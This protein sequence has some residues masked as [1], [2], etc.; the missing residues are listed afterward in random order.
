MATT[1]PSWK[2]KFLTRAKKEGYKKIL[3]KKV[4]VTEETEAIPDSDPD[5]KEK[6]ANREL[7]ENAYADLIL[8]ID[9]T[10]A[11]GRSV[12]NLIKNTK[13]DDY[14]DGN[15][16]NAWTALEKKFEPKTAPSQAKLHRLFY[17][18][19]MKKD[20]DPINF[21]TYLE[22][23]RSRLADAGIKMD[24]EH[25]I[26]QVL[27]TVTKGYATE[28]RL[29]EEKLDKSETV[30]IDNLKDRLSLEFERVL[31]WKKHE[32]KNEDE[33]EESDEENEKAFFS[34]QSK[35]RCK[36]CGKYGHKA[37]RCRQRMKDMDNNQ[38]HGKSNRTCNY[39][40]KYGHK[41]SNCRN[42]KRDEESANVVCEEHEFVFN[43]VEETGMKCVECDRKNSNIFVATNT[44][45]ADSG[46]SCRMTNSDEDMNDAKMIDEFV[47]IGNGKEMRATKM[48]YVTRMVKQLDG[49]S[50]KVTLKVKF[51]HDL[52]INLFSLTKPLEN[53]SKLGNDV[54]Y[55]TISKG[56]TTIKFDKI[57]KTKTGFVGAVE[58]APLPLKD[59]DNITLDKGRSV[60][61]TT[62]HDFLGHAGEHASR[63]MVD[64]YSWKTTGKLFRCEARQSPI[65][66]KVISHSKIPGK[67]LF[68]DISSI[69]S[70]S[71]GGSNFLLL[72]I[73]DAT[74]FNWSFFFKKKGD[75]RTAVR[76]LMK[77]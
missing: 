60:K 40:G 48:G 66:N 46:A 65:P 67:R 5:K 55:I 52:W 14:P 49:T 23:I 15:A 39:C 1:W 10:K 57:L 9:A 44:W 25:F 38:N 3:Q 41:E 53:G 26:L 13:S 28:V 37:S 54:I 18:D 77:T 22:D 76:E 61:L 70:K 59:Q 19:E 47:K 36:Y 29:I 11:T 50:K 51:V 27:N 43:C 2:E 72:I 63:L 58:V 30:T 33:S 31:K 71:L 45:I 8:S 68:I 69:K 24:D 64:Y 75:L 17:K 20:L 35:G 21:I 4:K 12:F 34:T 7:N 6:L 73:D 56:D 42:K 16:G 74:V 32:K 62:L